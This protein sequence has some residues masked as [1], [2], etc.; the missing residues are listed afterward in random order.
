MVTKGISDI[1][2]KGDNILMIWRND[3]K[4]EELK[5]VA[6]EIKVFTCISFKH[7]S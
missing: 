2:S 3:I 7:N 1:F 6:D 4:P 5:A